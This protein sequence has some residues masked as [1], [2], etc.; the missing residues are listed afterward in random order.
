MART[1]ETDEVVFDPRRSPKEDSQGSNDLR[2]TKENRCARPNRVSHG[3][4]TGAVGPK[5]TVPA[6]VPFSV[7]RLGGAQ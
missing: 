1:A 4:W 3:R 6:G 2:V 5:L 7:H